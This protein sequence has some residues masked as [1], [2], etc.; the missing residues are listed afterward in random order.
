MGMRVASAKDG[1]DGLSKLTD[2]AAWADDDPPYLFALVDMG[3]PGM[4]GCEM[5]RRDLTMP[6]SLALPSLFIC[7]APVSWAAC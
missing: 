4:D 2:P 5:A 3:M 6:Q 1:F 7:S